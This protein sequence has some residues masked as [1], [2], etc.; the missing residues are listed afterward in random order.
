MVILIENQ[1]YSYTIFIYLVMLHCPN[2]P[3]NRYGEE[4]DAASCDAAND[5]QTCDDT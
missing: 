4:E 2:E 1:H 5:G 3:Y